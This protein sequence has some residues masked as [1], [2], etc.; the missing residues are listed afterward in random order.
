MTSKRPVKRKKGRTPEMLDAYDD[1]MNFIGSFIRP[2]VHYNKMWH[3]VAQCWIIGLGD[4]GPRVFLQRRSFEKK[5]NPGRYDVSAGGHISS[6]EEP[7][8]AMVREI[9]EETG[10]ILREHHLMEVGT[11]KEVSGH[12]RELAHIFV[13]FEIDP[14]FY[15][16]K[17]VIYMVSADLEE[18]KAL[19]EGSVDSI[20]VV[21][22]I[23]TG[24]MQKEAFKV[25]QENFC[26]HESFVTIVYPYVKKYL[27]E[28]GFQPG[29]SES[30]I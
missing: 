25:T 21:P 11:C 24:P 19:S 29:G 10:L 14:P 1:D 3:K 16:G 7:K 23:R 5:S 6:G 28:H 20:T 4:S 17:E 18:F 27:A 22:A 2:A 12:D 13:H 15:P 8:T 30:R 9:Q 26:N